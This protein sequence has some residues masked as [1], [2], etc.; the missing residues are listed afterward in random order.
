MATGYRWG[1]DGLND[2]DERQQPSQ[3]PPIKHHARSTAAACATALYARR[4]GPRRRPAC[5]APPVTPPPLTTIQQ[6]APTNW[7]QQQIT[8]DPS[9]GGQFDIGIYDPQGGSGGIGNTIFS[10]F[11]DLTSPFTDLNSVSAAP[12]GQND[13]TSAVP[14][15]NRNGPP[16]VGIALKTP[17]STYWNN[18]AAQTPAPNSMTASVEPG[19][20][21]VYVGGADISAAEPGVGGTPYLVAQNNYLMPFGRFWVVALIVSLLVMINVTIL[22]GMRTVQR[23]V[24]RP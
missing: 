2:V 11:S 14:P 15:T 10:P 6:A 21:T 16:V 8:G 18:A 20:A 19:V 13:L 7:I 17:S 9:A 3:Q 1:R 22:W 23:L 4:V 5:R 24:A 12:Q